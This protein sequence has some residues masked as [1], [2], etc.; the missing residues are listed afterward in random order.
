MIED[1]LQ[2]GREHCAREVLEPVEVYTDQAMTGRKKDR[3]GFLKLLADADGAF[4]TI[5]TGAVGRLSRNLT[6]TLEAWDLFT[7]RGIQLYSVI[8]GP[9]NFMTVLLQGYGAQMLS[10]MIGAHMKRG[11]QGA[12][13][14]N[15]T[16]SSAYGYDIVEDAAPCPGH[17][18]HLRAKAE[19]ASTTMPDPATLFEGAIARMEQLLSDPDLVDQTGQFLRPIIRRVVLIPD[20]AA[21][22]GLSAKLETDFAA[23]LAPEL[24][25]LPPAHLMC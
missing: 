18:R 13:A 6:H 4:D 21:Q 23:L 12:L 22:H 2:M 10:E 14:R 1:Q 5:V 17:P 15:R 25:G 8:E 16:H 24:E 11:M 7:L 3:P 20:P 19:T 9:Q